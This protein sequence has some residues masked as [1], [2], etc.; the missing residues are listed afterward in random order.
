MWAM[1]DQLV[2]ALGLFF[3][4][5]LF[6]MPT[7][8]EQQLESS[9]RLVTFAKH[10][11]LS[12]RSAH[13]DH[14]DEVHQSALQSCHEPTN[15]MMTDY[16]PLNVHNSRAAGVKPLAANVRGHV[17]KIGSIL[18]DSV[19]P[20]RD[21]VDKRVA[22]LGI[23]NKYVQHT[24]FERDL[25][26]IAEE[27]NVAADFRVRTRSAFSGEK[28]G[29]LLTAAHDLR[30]SVDDRMRGVSTLYA[31]HTVDNVDSFSDRQDVATEKSRLD[32]AR[33]SGASA[34]Q[35]QLW[36]MNDVSPASSVAGS[37]HSSLDFGSDEK[38]WPAY[39]YGMDLR[40]E[41]G[42][43]SSE[44]SS[45][46]DANSI[47]N[48]GV[49]GGHGGYGYGGHA[50]Y[51]GWSSS[52][53]ETDDYETDSR[54]DHHVSDDDS[55]RT[56]FSPEP[57][58]GSGSEWG[59]ISHSSSQ[60][61]GDTSLMEYVRQWPPSA[62]GQQEAIDAYHSGDRHGAL[63]AAQQAYGPSADH[64]RSTSGGPESREGSPMTVPSTIRQ[65]GSRALR[66]PSVD[67]SVDHSQSPGRI[68]ATREGSPVAGP[69]TTRQPASQEIRHLSVDRSRSSSRIPEMPEG[70][71]VAG[72]STSR[73]AASPAPEQG[74]KRGHSEIS[75]DSNADGVAEAS[76]PSS[77]RQ[78]LI[79]GRSRSP[80]AGRDM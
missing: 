1:L 19:P 48:N 53:H 38:I 5:K 46:W 72:P 51:E 37:E 24:V 39:D 69:S 75:N 11:K 71:A 10:A 26:G 15:V 40:P 79:E 7:Y 23:L 22:A 44:L 62:P 27:M 63:V 54:S 58:Y 59:G 50:G 70:L 41:R 13:L 52:D 35:R 9:E 17:E 8:E 30:T 43:S 56:L 32:T 64:S 49:Y 66:N 2:E 6:Q 42:S 61:S 73:Q 18:D 34:S 20:G 65:P 76:G 31:D 21:G 57:G 80:S 74:R 14:Y 36:N 60:Q 55:Q 33:Y 4:R 3:S 67:H 25:G 77:K 45:F 47:S 12:F 28:V 16:I 68:P 29:A 78:Q